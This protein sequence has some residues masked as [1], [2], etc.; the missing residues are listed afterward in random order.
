MLF[1][2][3]IQD[4]VSVASNLIKIKSKLFTPLCG[5]GD[6]RLRIISD[7]PLN[8]PIESLL[9]NFGPVTNGAKRK[10]MFDVT[11]VTLYKHSETSAIF[12]P[13][14]LEMIRNFKNLKGIRPWKYL[15]TQLNKIWMYVMH[16]MRYR[17]SRY[18]S[19]SC[20]S[21]ADCRTPC[22]WYSSEQ[23]SVWDDLQS[24]VVESYKAK[25]MERRL[26]SDFNEFVLHLV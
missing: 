1:F 21:F 16:F 15:G 3:V 13:Y 23:I 25:F 8:K 26:G 22:S 2:R 5:S 12:L 4:S 14:R 19:L 7:W 20:I 9:P 18:Q 6:I 11:D 24:D 10:V 17:I